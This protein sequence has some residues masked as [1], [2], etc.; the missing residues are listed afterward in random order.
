M[1]DINL[2]AKYGD[3]FVIIS[4]QGQLIHGNKPDI[5]TE[6]NLAKAYS[7][8]FSIIENNGNIFIQPNI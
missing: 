2:A 3:K 4:K 8:D 7:I 6:F 5:L 1:H